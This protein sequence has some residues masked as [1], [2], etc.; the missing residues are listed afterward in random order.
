M[1]PRLSAGILLYRRTAT[2]GVEVLLAHMG[3]PYWAGKDDAA[4]SIPK[5]EY[6]ADEPPWDAARREFAEEIGQ[7]APDGTPLDLG[8]VTQRNG[9]VVTAYAL[10]GDLDP[11]TMHSNTFELEWPPRS[12]RMQTFPEMDRAAWFAPDVARAKALASQ[13]EL[14][15]RLEQQLGTGPP[16]P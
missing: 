2:G 3:G 12:G 15:V 7:P 6:D 14:I 10:E 4:W 5:G 13:G 9:K 11:E 16:E 8:S 1:T